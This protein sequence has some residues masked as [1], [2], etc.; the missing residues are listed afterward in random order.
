MYLLPITKN[1]S[2][3]LGL[4]QRT[5]G[6]AIY[7]FS[8]YLQGAEQAVGFESEELADLQLTA[9]CFPFAHAVAMAISS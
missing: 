9:K 2:C 4:K 8:D 6:K 1:F 5:R 3:K 7:V